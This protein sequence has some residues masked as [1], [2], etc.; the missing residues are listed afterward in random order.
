ME[1]VVNLLNRVSIEPPIL[2]SKPV[3]IEDGGG[4]ELTSVLNSNGMVEGLVKDLS[5]GGESGFKNARES[6][7]VVELQVGSGV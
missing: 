4:P 7:G 3:S 5:S 1:D 2:A 6:A